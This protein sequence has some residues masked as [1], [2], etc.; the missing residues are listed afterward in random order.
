MALLGHI[1]RVDKDTPEQKALQ[2]YMTSHKCPV[3]RPP[4]NW[5]KLITQDLT[6]TATSKA[7]LTQPPSKN[8][9]VLAKDKDGSK[10]EI[11]SP[12]YILQ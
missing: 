2:F 9:K 3:G 6:N 5:T 12:I 11:V 7:P 8:L 4:L 10:R 1:L